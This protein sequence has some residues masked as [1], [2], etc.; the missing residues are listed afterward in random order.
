MDL[1]FKK[2]AQKIDHSK[3]LAAGIECG[4]GSEAIYSSA[5]SYFDDLLCDIDCADS[6]IEL[7]VYIFTLDETGLRFTNALLNAS[8][9]GVK[10]RLLVDGVGSA[11]DAETI[12]RRLSGAGSEVRI[13]HPLPW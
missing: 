4:W 13:Y 7:A 10:V 12:A 1:P 11:I 6:S 9:R 8:Q 2:A 5:K 3:S